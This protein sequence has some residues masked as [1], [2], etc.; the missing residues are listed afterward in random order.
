MLFNAARKSKKMNRL[1]FLSYEKLFYFSV[2]DE[3]VLVKVV[4]LSQMLCFQLPLSRCSKEKRE[5]L[6]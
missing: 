1:A 4:S 6:R 5:A 2:G 3:S